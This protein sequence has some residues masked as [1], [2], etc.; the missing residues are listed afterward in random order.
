MHWGGKTG[1]YKWKYIWK[2]SPLK[3]EGRQSTSLGFVMS[4]ANYFSQSA[5]FANKAPNWLSRRCK[6]FT[7]PNLFYTE[8][9][10]V[11]L[12]L[13]NSDLDFINYWKRFTTESSLGTGIKFYENDIRGL[14]S[15]YQEASMNFPNTF[16]KLLTRGNQYTL[17]FKW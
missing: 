15:W 5:T 16:W 11:T 9:P 14:L 4:I 7:E 3:P 2:P 1:T 13:C 17:N 12:N 6:T 10:A 8:C